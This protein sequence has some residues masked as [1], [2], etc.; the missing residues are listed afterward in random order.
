MPYLDWWAFLCNS[1]YLTEC[2]FEKGRWT[3]T[4]AGHYQF[5]FIDPQVLLLEE[6]REL[7]KS[8]PRKAQE[9]VAT[10]D[11]KILQTDAEQ[12]ATLYHSVDVNL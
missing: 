12:I 2:C 9:S 11:V 4:A 1:C 5:D 7:P 10:T 3:S 6:F 8:N